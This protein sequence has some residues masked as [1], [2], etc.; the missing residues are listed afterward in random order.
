MPR[1]ARK[2]KAAADAPPSPIEFKQL[3]RYVKAR[4]ALTTAP[5]VP[6]E[7]SLYIAGAEPR[8]RVEAVGA[9]DGSVRVNLAVQG[10]RL[11]QHAFPPSIEV[12]RL[13]DTRKLM[14][15]S[16]YRE[17]VEGSFPD[18][19]GLRT[20][21]ERLA[22]ALQV[23]PRI[24][25]LRKY[26]KGENQ[27]TTVFAPEN[28]YIFNDTNFPWCTTGRID[29]AGGQGSGVIIGPRHV[30]TV[31]HAMVWN[32]DGTAGWVKFTPSYFNGSAPFGIAWGVLVYFEVKV[33][34]P[35]IDNNEGRHDYVV[36]VLD[37]R[38]GD[39][40]GWMGSRT[41]SD[42]WDGGTY[43]SHIGYPGDLSGGERPSFEGSIA[44]DGTDDPEEHQN[45]LHRGDVWP[46]QSGGPFFGWWSGE[47][48]PRVVSVQSWQNSSDNG[49]SGGRHM[50]DLVIRARN[51]NP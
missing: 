16:A 49:A 31:S 42:S 48:W 3:S 51:E 27:A 32:S 2:K 30:L 21:P 24:D 20:A 33:V 17:L 40:T 4:D 35:G 18:H 8:A 10:A 23:P 22:R 50:V 46:G 37:R 25:A 9:K 44:L 11:G 39:L 29:T 1:K 19:L 13:P 43:W 38:M 26:R 45:I 6:L 34:G 41:Y 5:S 14:S 7:F 12:R 15:S 36:V 28:R 47:P